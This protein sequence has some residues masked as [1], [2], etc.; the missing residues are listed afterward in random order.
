MPLLELPKQISVAQFTVPEGQPSYSQ[1]FHDTMGDA[2]TPADGFDATFAQMAL[3]TSSAASIADL[4]ATDLQ[5]VTDIAS[6]F[7]NAD[8]G[9]LALSLQPAQDATDAALSDYHT[10]V[11]PTVTPTGTISGGPAASVCKPGQVV[12]GL[13]I[14]Q[15]DP[16][17]YPVVKVNPPYVY[18]TSMPVMCLGDASGVFTVQTGTFTAD[19]SNYGTA[20]LLFGDPAIFS[21]A[22]NKYNDLGSSWLEDV[23]LT[24]TPSKAGRFTAVVYYD[25][26][27]GDQF[28]GQHT[29][30]YNFTIVAP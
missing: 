23:L 5:S 20:R 2:G 9:D 24:V 11:P 4:D 6:G 27:G 14:G 3:M 29:W 8:E 12:A 15:K 19:Q 16:N 10:V 17:P 25:E 22:L 28:G 13:T 26:A 21:L 7:N 1:I 30:A 18:S